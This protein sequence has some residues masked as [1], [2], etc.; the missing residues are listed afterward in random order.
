MKTI[1]LAQIH[2]GFGRPGSYFK[3]AK[4][5]LY[6]NKSYYSFKTALSRPFITKSN[7]SIIP[8]P[9]MTDEKLCLKWNDFQDVVQASLGE[10]R[11]ENDFTDVT[12]ACEDQSLK[13][14]R[15]IL[16]SCSPFF[17]R[18]LKTHSQAQPL[19]YM[20]G[21]KF[22][23]LVAIVD[24][25]YEGQAKVF[26]EELDNFLSLAEELELKGLSGGSEAKLPEEETPSRQYPKKSEKPNIRFA[27]KE[28]TFKGSNSN[29]EAKSNVFQG[30]I[31]SSNQKETISSLIDPE[32]KRIINSLIEKQLDRYTCL[33]CDYTSNDAG[34]AK[35]HAER[36]IEGL[37]YPCNFCGKV[38]RSSESFKHHMRDS[39]CKKQ[40]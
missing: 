8:A 40:K 4:D 36:H 7:H 2:F 29:P 3:A 1:K 15:V 32:T 34:N 22:S 11:S 5:L 6:T 30:A 31:V 28:T 18:L 19:I 21:L 9:I 13:A 26:Q 27:A 35:K 20:R 23:D 39:R 33:K 10:L 25:I 24:F 17:K 38:Y 14:H 12:L 16:S 37:A